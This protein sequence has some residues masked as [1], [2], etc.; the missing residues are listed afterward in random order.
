MRRMTRRTVLESV[1]AVGLTG[2]TRGFAWGQASAPVAPGMADIESHRLLVQA[3]RK[4]PATLG[5]WIDRLC[6]GLKS[7]PERR[8]PLSAVAGTAPGAIGW[9][10]PSNNDAAIVWGDECVFLTASVVPV[11]IGI[12][13]RAPIAMRPVPGTRYWYL[14]RR[15]KL[16]ATHNFTF[17]A[18]DQ[19]L[20]LYTV[21]GYTPD[22]YP[23]AGLRRGTMSEK[24][25]IT[26]TLYGGAKSDYW[27][28]VNPGVDTERGVPLMVWLDGGSHVGD[29]DW[30]GLRMQVVTDNLVQ[31]GR[32]PPMVHLLINPGHDGP[33]QPS[34]FPDQ[35]GNAQMRSLQYDTVSDL[36]ARHMTEEVLPEV[37]KR[38]RLRS[39]G[40]SHA[41]AGQS[42]GG[43]ACFKLG[44][45]RPDLF[46]RL[47]PSIA[48]FTA[49]GLQPESGVTGGFL[50]PYWVRR[51]PRKNLRVWLSESR[52]GIDVAEDG[53]RDMYIA[54][55]WPLA[56][57]A[58]AQALKTRL[59]DFHFRFGEGY[60]NMAQQ[61][62][63][64]PEALT[65]LWRGYDPA[66][67]AETF[68][69]EASERAQPLYRVGIT[70][71][72]AE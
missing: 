57:L 62:L 22:S 29:K 66:R 49:L 38:V 27:L 51:E 3:A 15:I 70:N 60:H 59:Y 28:Y 4:D 5:M 61:G 44:W 6:P 20:D 71:R 53:R 31:Q 2:L 8:E 39:D 18:G 36:F 24:R 55:S 1:G 69:Q 68:E 58:M 65:W 35:D 25:T 63:D 34:Q 9:G 30:R 67:T 42:S 10:N 54:G 56:N 48:G 52:N 21:A 40:Y 33:A 23:L 46:S 19:A 41:V 72:S 45:Y 13:D 64:L 14:A 32:I 11:T 12:D 43:T 50:F 7:L 16:N 37:G 26:S 17:F 47:M